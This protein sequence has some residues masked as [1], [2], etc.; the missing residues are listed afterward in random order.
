MTSGPSAVALGLIAAPGTLIKPPEGVLAFAPVLKAILSEAP[1]ALAP[2]APTTT[3][4]ATR[5][6]AAKTAINP[7]FVNI[8]GL[9]VRVASILP[10]GAGRLKPAKPP[11]RGGA[12]LWTQ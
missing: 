5:T 6:A 9:L 8:E 3:T 7:G 1:L 11:F 10:S 12:T 2:I 4:P